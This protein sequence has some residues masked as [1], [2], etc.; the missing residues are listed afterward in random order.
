M[1]R[2]WSGKVGR[3]LRK[4]ASLFNRS[5]PLRLSSGVLA[6]GD[7]DIREKKFLGKILVVC[8]DTGRKDKTRG[9]K[10]RIQITPRVWGESSIL[11]VLSSTTTL[12][13][14]FNQY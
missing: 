13:T 14:P 2:V 1:V 11:K 6:L 5:L 8:R 12:T 9:S 4:T 7:N 10:Y 3:T